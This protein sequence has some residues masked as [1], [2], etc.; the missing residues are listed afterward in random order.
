MDAE[1]GNWKLR[2][3]LVVLALAGLPAT[4]SAARADVS[5]PS[6]DSAGGPALS[7]ASRFVVRADDC[8]TDLGSWAEAEGLH[9]AGQ[10]VTLMRAAG[11]ESGLVEAWLTNANATKS[12]RPTDVTITLVSSANQPLMTWRLVDVLPLWW[13]LQAFGPDSKLA[14]ETLELSHEGLARGGPC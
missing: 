14:L 6:R 11:R 7:L 12:L 10:T 3:A 2:A 1:R 13:S 8:H 4:C 9:V 5:S